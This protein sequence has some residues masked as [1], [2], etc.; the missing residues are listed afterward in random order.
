MTMRK[1]NIVEVKNNFTGKWSKGFE[2]AEVE[3]NRYRLRRL[4]DG[5]IIPYR[6]TSRDLRMKP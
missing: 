3:Q 6:F 2:I 4:S 1:G 5:S